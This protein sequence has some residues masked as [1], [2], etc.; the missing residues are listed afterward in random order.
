MAD[1][2]DR[3]TLERYAEAQDRGAFALQR[4]I[5]SGQLAKRGLLEWKGKSFG[6]DFYSI[7]PAGRDALKGDG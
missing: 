6:T 2:D 5:L 3:A 1:N 7:T 4:L